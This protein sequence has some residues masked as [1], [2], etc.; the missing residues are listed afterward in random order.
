[1]SLISPHCF[2]PPLYPYH[3]YPN[4]PAVI[5]SYP[6]L[7]TINFSPHSLIIFQ[8]PFHTKPFSK[9]GSQ[10]NS[11]QLPHYRQFS[12]VAKTQNISP[13]PPSRCHRL[14]QSLLSTRPA[15]SYF[16]PSFPQRSTLLSLSPLLSFAL[17]LPTP[18]L[19]VCTPVFLAFPSHQILLFPPNHQ[20]GVDTCT[21]SSLLSIPTQF[22]SWYRTSL[23]QPH[24][25]ASVSSVPSHQRL[26]VH[27]PHCRLHMHSFPFQEPGLSIPKPPLK[28]L[29]PTACGCVCRPTRSYM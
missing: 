1:M 14:D 10:V 26:S 23:G 9:F 27:R 16:L 24:T 25:P 22:T 28:S 29:C 12:C 3:L 21:V 13:Y 2:H 7:V 4:S 19:R 6:T 11:T 18:L 17:T 20:S 8:F 15:T 5:K